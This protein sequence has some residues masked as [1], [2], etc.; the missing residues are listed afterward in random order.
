MKVS[1]VVHS[2]NQQD[3]EAVDKKKSAATKTVLAIKCSLMNWP[4]TD[5]SYFII[6]TYN[7]A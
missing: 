6:K 2:N 4:I 1:E 7:V 5:I 3:K